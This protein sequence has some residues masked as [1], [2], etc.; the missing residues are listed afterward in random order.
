MTNFSK[1]SDL[2][3]P[4][5]PDV[6]RLILGAVLLD[7]S[8]YAQIAST[9][10]EDQF[11]DR[12]NR[13]IFRAMS[14]LTQQGEHIDRITVYHELDRAGETES[15]DGLS[16][17]VSLD[18]GLP[19]LPNIDSYVRMVREKAD[20]RRVMFTCQRLLQR[21]SSEREDA[22]ALLSEM[23]ASALEAEGRGDG[24]GVPSVPDLPSVLDIASAE[25]RWTVGGWIAEGTV[26]V[27]T[28]EPGAGK[29]TLALAVASAIASG[30]KFAGMATTKRPALVLDRENGAAFMADVLKRLHAKDGDGLRIWGGW[31]PE[32][33]PDP[34]SAIVLGWALGCDPRP[35]I[36]V[37]SLVAFH[38]GDE[39]DSTETRAFMQHCRRLAD[40]GGTVLLL[41]HSGKAE[42]SA[43][44]R[45]SSD[46][47][48]AA[49]ACFKLSNIGPTNCIERIRI[50][51]FKSR[52]LV[53]PE[54]VLT[55]SDGVFS[56]EG[57]GGSQRRTDAELLTEILKA[58]P[59]L[60]GNEL[61]R[62]A[63]ERGVGRNYARNWLEGRVRD[64]LIRVTHGPKNAKLYTWASEADG[65]DDD[66]PF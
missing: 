46:I 50:K 53:E 15:C 17:L 54:I 29:T 55:Y 26:N 47:K 45:G 24:A 58:H 65:N 19:R 23:A 30:E 40:L 38:G 44:Y 7:G 16:Y 61:E 66:P 2:T 33:A 41:H 42:S 32:D 52:F 37:D 49:D 39:N 14:R 18:D 36:I 9:L 13:L 20:L 8:L 63:P 21:A 31:L 1:T 4:A 62:L 35:F 28:S 11:S 27:L 51:P 56:R 57:A 5:A 34:A 60:K 25:V 59:A 48:A 10:R 6:E 64:G 3:L 22:S 12:R 43:D